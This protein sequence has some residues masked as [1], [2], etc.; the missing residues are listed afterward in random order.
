MLLFSPLCMCVGRE[1]VVRGVYNSRTHRSFTSLTIL[2]MSLIFLNFSFLIN[3]N[4]YFIG[5]Y[6]N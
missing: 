6:E 4:S 3:G 2:G 5:C 1:V